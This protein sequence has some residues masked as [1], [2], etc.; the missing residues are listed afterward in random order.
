M[1]RITFMILFLLTLVAPAQAR[2]HRHHYYRPH[3]AVIQQHEWGWSSGLTPTVASVTRLPHP[4]GC[5]SR[6]FCGCGVSVD[7]FGHPVR[8][9]YLAAAWRRFPPAAPAPGM[10]AWRAHHVMRLRQQV[11]GSVWLVYDP[12]GGRGGTWLHERDIR[13]YRIVSPS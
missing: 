9:L 12:N 1:L 2:H 6:L 8:G 13:G 11:R 4:S 10:V 7:V 5:P 3:V